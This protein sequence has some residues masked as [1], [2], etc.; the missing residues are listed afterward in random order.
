MVNH[1]LTPA[2]KVAHLL[3]RAGFGGSPAEVAA[4]EALDLPTI[5]DR[6]LDVSSA[7]ALPAPASLG[8]PDVNN[9]EQWVA[10]THA[11]LDRM[12]TAPV[13]LVEKMTLFWHG[14]FCSS[15]DKVSSTTAMWNQ[16]QLFRTAGLGRFSEL[17]KAVALDPAMLRYLDNH[18]NVVGAPNENFARESMELFTLGVNQY[19]QDDVV[20]VARA[21][22][23]HGLEKDAYKFTASRH[24]N[25]QKTIFGMARNWDGPAVLD[26]IVLG[27]KRD[28]SA[29][30]VVAKLWS[31]FA[32]PNPEPAVVDALSAA[33]L[34]AGSNIAAALRVLFLREE[35]YGPKAIRGLVRTPI[36]YV[37]ATMRSLGFNSALAHPEWYLEAM[38]QRPFAPPN[39][40]GWRSNAYWVSTSAQWAK[41]DFAGYVRWEAQKRGY[42]AGTDKL[43][44]RDAV[45]HALRSFGID[46]PSVWTVGAMEGWLR[47][48][49]RT[50][51]WAE[52][53]NLIM[54]S[55]LSPDM[56]LA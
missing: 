18:R 40:S 56:Q 45:L 4:F 3:R 24:D 50:T 34:A 14:H 16:N 35:F 26:E 31:F 21:W 10:M 28:V 29:R 15:V 55:L 49:R 6:L 33:Y 1:M 37:V 17:A 25:G 41:A 39:V 11:W 48:E 13:P 8:N 23:G 12:A 54:L 20:A 2:W 46:A 27:T 19:T 44:P 5:V 43:A 51:R 30:F 53:P 22:T 9:W 36:E 42:L 47:E 7:P 32:Y 52:Q 38:G